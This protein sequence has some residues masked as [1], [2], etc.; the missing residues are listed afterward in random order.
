MFY[1]FLVYYGVVLPIATIPCLLFLKPQL[2]Q[3]FITNLFILFLHAELQPNAVSSAK[4][5]AA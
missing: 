3:P 1:H 4:L 2:F 5:N